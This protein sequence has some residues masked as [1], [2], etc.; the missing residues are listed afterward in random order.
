MASFTPVWISGSPHRGMEFRDPGSILILILGR[1]T[2][3]DTHYLI[4]T[5][6]WRH[7]ERAGVPNHRRPDCLVRRESKKTSKFSVT[8]FYEVISPHKVPITR[9]MLPFDD[10]FMINQ[11]SLRGGND[12]F[13]S[14]TPS[15][16][17]NGKGQAWFLGLEQSLI[18]SYDKIWGI[19]VNVINAKKVGSSF[20]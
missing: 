11:T 7:N 5:L 3:Y 19:H 18:I 12:T 10:V 13:H 8:G 14:C 9:K 16:D 17:S 1:V 15:D 6:Q 4:L 20:L 2:P